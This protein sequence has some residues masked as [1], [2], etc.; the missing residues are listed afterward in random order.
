MYLD[1]A[2]LENDTSGTHD[3]LVCATDMKIAAPAVVGHKKGGM[4]AR[5]AHRHQ[6]NLLEGVGVERVRRVGNVVVVI[7]EEILTCR[8][9]IH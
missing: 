8:I 3:L 6:C 2:F 9:G 7:L 1:G 5:Q 4:T